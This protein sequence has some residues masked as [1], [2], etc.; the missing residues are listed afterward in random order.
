MQYKCLQYLKV[1]NK[2]Y[3]K[4]EVVDLSPLSSEEIKRLE[5]KGIIEKTTDPIT[6]QIESKVE[7]VK[8]LNNEED[9]EMTEDDV[10]EELNS[11]LTQTIVVRELELLGVEFKKNA[12]LKSLV[13]LIIQ[14]P[15]LEDHFLDYI[16]NNGL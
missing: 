8:E 9:D 10:R 12:S 15:K 2:Y 11:K 13:E 4:G 14:D 5:K 7:E 3:D 6:K 1:C 16:E